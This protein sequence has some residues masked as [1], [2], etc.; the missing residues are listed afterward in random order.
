MAD[1]LS[2]LI[3]L[4]QLGLIIDLIIVL[5]CFKA[6]T[7]EHDRD[8]Q[9][10]QIDERLRQLEKRQG[11]LRWV[12]YV[13]ISLIIFSLVSELLARKVYHYSRALLILNIELFVLGAL[14]CVATVFFV[15]LQT[16]VF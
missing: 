16:R 13:V 15:K 3:G 4:S 6:Q 2:V 10:E 12:N 7:R 14:L 5:W 8:T 1:A 9:G 11:T